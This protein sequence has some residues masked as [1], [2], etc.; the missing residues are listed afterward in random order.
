VKFRDLIQMLR[1]AG[2]VHVR[3]TGSHL[4]FKHPTKPGVITVP[5]GGKAG[6]DI[7]PGT[8]RAILR[9]AG[10]LE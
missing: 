8:L 9:Q 7:A 2:W 6:R 3:T 1:D 5:G 10:L 4:H